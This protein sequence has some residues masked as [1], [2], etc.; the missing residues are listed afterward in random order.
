MPPH[1]GRSPAGPCGFFMI[2]R[3]GARRIVPIRQCVQGLCRC[4]CPVLPMPPPAPDSS[5]GWSSS[6]RGLRR[7]VPASACG[8]LAAR[9]AHVSDSL[10]QALH[11]RQRASL[12]GPGRGPGQHRRGWTLHARVLRVPG[13]SLRVATCPDD[14]VLHGKPGDGRPALQAGRGG[15]GHSPVFYLRL[16]GRL[17]RAQRRA[18]GLRRRTP[19]HPQPGRE[20]DRRG[21]DPANPRHLRRAL[22]G[23]VL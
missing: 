7:S 18:T 13:A 6:A 23:C 16:H 9:V 15:R 14:P 11:R 21:G 10:R 22:R 17:L 4:C 19:R 2:G 20:P 1:P 12:R 3:S 5:S 8:R